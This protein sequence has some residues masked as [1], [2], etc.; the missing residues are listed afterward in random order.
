MGGV[1]WERGRMGR[2]FIKSRDAIVVIDGDDS[3][4]GGVLNGDV[5]RTDHRV[6]LLGDQPVIHLRVIHLVDMVAGQH[7][8]E[9]RMFIINQEHVLI[10][11]IC[12]SAIPILADALLRRDGRNVFPEFG[13]Q[14]VPSGADMTVE[15]M[16]LVLD[17][18]HDFAESG[19]EAIAQC[20]IDDPVFPPKRNGGLSPLFRKWEK[21]FA[22]ASG[23]NY[24]KDVLHAP[25][26]NRTGCKWKETGMIDIPIPAVNT[27]PQ[28]LSKRRMCLLK[29]LTKGGA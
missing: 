15:R 1:V 4:P 3:E 16:G 27:S 2:F 18:D 13:V 28:A 6:G 29:I 8:E 14:D 23:K 22:L 7:E 17:Q 11:G 24:R 19:V 20:E 5:D 26:S 21:P 10:D 9:F 12:G 25:D